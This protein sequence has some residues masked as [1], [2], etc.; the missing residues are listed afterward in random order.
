MIDPRFQ[1]GRNG[2]VIHRRFNDKDVAGHDLGDQCPGQGQFRRVM[3]GEHGADKGGVNVRHRVL[4]QIARNNR[5]A[6]MGHFQA[7]HGGRPDFTSERVVEIAAGGD[8]EDGGHD[9]S[10]IAVDS[11]CIY[12][13]L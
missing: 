2:E 1:H 13:N 12:S 9:S 10:F 8:M 5:C 4:N 6:R 11:Q 3:V 7:L